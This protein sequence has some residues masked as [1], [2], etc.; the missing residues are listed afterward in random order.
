MR[1]EACGNRKVANL[2]C[3]VIAVAAIAEG[4]LGLGVVE[5]DRR[6]HRQVGRS[7]QPEAARP[8]V[9]GRR[10]VRREHLLDPDSF[11]S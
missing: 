11:C 4:H 8:A 5:G 6:S 10:R 1:H 2:T 3:A 9:G 7:V